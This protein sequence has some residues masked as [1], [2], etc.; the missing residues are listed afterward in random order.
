LRE[1]RNASGGS[2]GL[3]GEDVREEVKEAKEIKEE[4]EPRWVA[5]N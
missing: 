1:E 5:G 3:P 4:N 2:L